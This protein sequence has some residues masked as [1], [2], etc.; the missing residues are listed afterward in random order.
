MR[1]GTTLETTDT[2]VALVYDGH[3]APSVV[4]KGHEEQAQQILELARAAGVPE[5][6]HPELARALAQ[7]PTGDAVPPALYRAVAQVIAFAYLAVGKL[8]EGFAP[9]D[10]GALDRRA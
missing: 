8:P 4:A 1:N 3:N 6:P 5:Y 9:P 10:A 7:I 2:A